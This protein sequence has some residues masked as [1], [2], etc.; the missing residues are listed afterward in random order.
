MSVHWHVLR[1]VAAQVLPGL[2]CLVVLIGVLVL[3]FLL[4]R[5]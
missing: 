4:W 5:L 3:T 1:T 2:F